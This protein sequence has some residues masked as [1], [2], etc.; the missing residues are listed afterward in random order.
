MDNGKNLNKVKCSVVRRRA[1]RYLA[2]QHGF[3]IVGVACACLLGACAR[4]S[5]T[6]AAAVPPS[7]P[8]FGPVTVSSELAPTMKR[9]AEDA[10]EFTVRLD[11]GAAL[12]L[13]A[14]APPRVKPTTAPDGT[15]DG[16]Q[17]EASFG[18]GE[19]GCVLFHKRRDASVLRS[20]VLD[21]AP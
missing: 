15:P 19:L 20:V 10:R 9:E 6:T 13:E 8:R 12:T 3:C 18:E 16:Y 5:S 7:T 17:I 14:S 1:L 21:S 4:P 11:E 2:P